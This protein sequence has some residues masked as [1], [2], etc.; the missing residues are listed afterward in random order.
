M[1]VQTTIFHDF[2]SFVGLHFGDENVWYTACLFIG[3]LNADCL[4]WSK[5][6]YLFL[7][8]RAFP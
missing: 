1:K 8:T 2:L 3:E 6:S 7:F 5:A 4:V